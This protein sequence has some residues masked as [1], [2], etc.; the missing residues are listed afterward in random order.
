MPRLHEKSPRLGYALAA[1]A[2][3]LWAVNG[4]LA[5]LLLT[6]RPVWLLDEPTAA[7]DTQGAAWIGGLI[8][9]HLGRGGIVV[10]ATHDE[11][12]LGASATR[13]LTLARSAA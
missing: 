9:A 11:L 6:D 4:S 13:T 8:A 1:I 5:R 7:L 12:A 2:A 10:A 3:T